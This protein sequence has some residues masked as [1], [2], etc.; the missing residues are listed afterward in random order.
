MSHATSKTI[1]KRKK[2]QPYLPK[3]TAQQHPYY[4]IDT[5]QVFGFMHHWA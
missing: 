3:N 2:K 1:Q 4:L 5:K